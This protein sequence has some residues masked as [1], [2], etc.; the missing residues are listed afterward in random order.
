MQGAPERPIW[1]IFELIQATGTRIRSSMFKSVVKGVQRLA[2]KLSLNGT[3]PATTQHW[4]DMQGSESREYHRRSIIVAV[5]PK[6]LLYL[7]VSSPSL[8]H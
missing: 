6:P 3:D 4:L 2:R 8:P 1:Y 5:I 7:L